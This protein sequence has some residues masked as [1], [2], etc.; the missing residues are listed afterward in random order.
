MAQAAQFVAAGEASRIVAGASEPKSDIVARV[1]WPL[2]DG[3]PSSPGAPRTDLAAA[4]VVEDADA[5]SA[6]GARALARIA[7]VV[8]WRGAFD[9]AAAAIAAPR[10]SRAEI[11]VPLV[12]ASADLDAFV[13]RTAWRGVPRVTGAPALGASDALGAAAL[14]IAVARIAEGRADEAL[15]VAVA[16]GRGFAFVLVAP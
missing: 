8:E 13:A 3:A 2:F 9:A 6:R 14:A 15:V 11:V 12:S 5:A 10:S 1:L 4:L 16:Q 7:Q